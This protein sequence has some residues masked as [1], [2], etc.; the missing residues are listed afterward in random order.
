M[1]VGE[2]FGSWDHLIHPLTINSEQAL[3]ADSNQDRNFWDGKKV[4]IG[5]HF[6]DILISLLGFGLFS[7]P[8][9]LLLT[10]K[11]KVEATSRFK[12]IYTSLIKPDENNLETIRKTI[13]VSNKVLQAGLEGND[14][15]NLMQSAHRKENTQIALEILELTQNIKAIETTITRSYSL[16]TF[17]QLLRKAYDLNLFVNSE[18]RSEIVDDDGEEKE[19][20]YFD[21]LTPLFYL[22]YNSN[23]KITIDNLSHHPNFNFDSLRQWIN[24]PNP[25]TNDKNKD[26]YTVLHFAAVK[27]EG[28][29]NY[30]LLIDFLMRLGADIN[31]QDSNDGFTPLHRACG[32]GS[33]EAVK[34]LLEHRPNTTLVSNYGKRAV[35]QAALATGVDDE[36]KESIIKLLL[37]PETNRDRLTLIQMVILDSSDERRV[38]YL[39]QLFDNGFAKAIDHVNAQGCTALQLAMDKG[40]IEAVK[41]LLERG[42]NPSIFGPGKLSPLALAVGKAQTEEAW[43]EIVNLCI[44]LGADVAEASSV[45]ENGGR[46]DDLARAA[47]QSVIL[48]TLA[49]IYPPVMYRYFVENGEVE[50]L[51]NEKDNFALVDSIRGYTPMQWACL[52]GN[53]KAV[54][55]LLNAGD[56]VNRK[57]NGRHPILLAALS[58]SRDRDDIVSLL[59]EHPTNT[60]KLTP[61]HLALTPSYV[62]NIDGTVVDKTYEVLRKVCRVAINYTNYQNSSGETPLHL[63]IDMGLDCVKVLLEN[64]AQQ[65]VNETTWAVMK[66]ARNK[67]KEIVDFLLQHQTNIAR[68]SLL[69]I[70]VNDPTLS[71]KDI[72]EL[73]NSSYN[74]IDELNGIDQTPLQYAAMRNAQLVTLLLDN[75]ANIE[76]PAKTK[77]SPL[78]LAMENVES[79]KMAVGY[80]VTKVLIERGADL[81]KGVHP[82]KGIA[83]V[84]LKDP[85]IVETIDRI[86]PSPLFR[87]LFSRKEIRDRINFKSIVD[88]NLSKI[89]VTDTIYGRTALHWACRLGL[90]DAVKVLLEAG[91]RIDIESKEGRNAITDANRSELPN[92]DAVVELMLRHATSWNDLNQKLIGNISPLHRAVDLPKEYSMALL[93]RGFHADGHGKAFKTPMRLAL[94]K[95]RW[96]L[97][98]ILLE[99]GANPDV[100]GKPIRRERLR[101]MAQRA[102]KNEILPYLR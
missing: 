79:H 81:S 8:I 98:L 52:R 60:E 48:D 101:L 41:L 94:E 23:S 4:S 99:W 57:V 2:I 39:N 18:E 88:D 102:N 97:V 36:V 22:L 95:R 53:Y 19:R 29:C 78:A 34:A 71:V 69:H 63:A 89:N 51:V 15:T 12:E 38:G 42:A 100:G 40:D 76:G 17:Y 77:L 64:G 85:A 9:Y 49:R 31:N 65:M 47:N 75:G 84:E 50:F 45:I 25:E 83:V 21:R 86:Y 16:E 73:I 32:T 26:V 5:F 28:D 13:Q 10:A 61:V 58:N 55:A 82:K 37:S 3:L 6:T 20:K 72:Q 93:G 24:I 87:Y 92:K 27:R 11:R 14:I 7:L 35:V 1:P 59:V 46:L 90:Y 70:A 56:V 96:D 43:W 54:K 74:K 67:K 80:S 66:A 68:E 30:K 91:A 44:S 33:L 62:E